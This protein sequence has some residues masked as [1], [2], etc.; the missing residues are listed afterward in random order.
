MERGR[1]GAAVT[2]LANPHGL[3][4]DHKITENDPDWNIIVW[5]R[6]GPC[7]LTLHRLIKQGRLLVCRS[8][9]LWLDG[10]AGGGG[11]GC[12]AAERTG[13]AAALRMIVRRQL[14][15]CNSGGLDVIHSIWHFA[16]RRQSTLAGL[17]IRSRKTEA[18]PDLLIVA[19]PL[20]KARERHFTSPSVVG[21]PCPF[22]V[23]G[24]CA[25]VV[26]ILQL[27]LVGL[28]EVQAGGLR[29]RSPLDRRSTSTS[30]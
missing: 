19:D 4:K 12:P 17:C 27:A 2:S 11:E 10:G 13:R 9:G 23:F 20:L 7:G 22:V 15:K 21:P 24:W 14:H 18:V 28:S 8:C 26:C 3:L 16:P 1:R 29:K 5:H 6:H 30:K 25:I